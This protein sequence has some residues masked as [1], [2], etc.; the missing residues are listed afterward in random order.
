MK[1]FLILILLV[2]NSIIA[3][4]EAKELLLQS[5]LQKILTYHA[6]HVP[7]PDPK[8][9]WYG[10]SGFIHPVRTPS[11]RIVTDDFPRDHLHQHGIMMAWT[12]SIIDGKKVDFWNSHKKQGVI[13]H[14]ETIRADANKIIVKLQHFNTTIQPPQ[15]VLHET[16]E[17]T[18]VPH[19]TMHVFDLVSTQTNVMT[20]PLKLAKYKYGGLCV[21]GSEAWRKNGSFLTSN[22]KT[23]INGNHSRPK[24]VALYGKIDGATCGIA[25]LGH[26][27]NFRAPQP[28]RIHPEFPYF[29]YAPMVTGE[30]KIEPAKPFISRYRF[31]AFD[32]EPATQKLNALWNSYTGR[33]N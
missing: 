13:K 25:C 23:R 2:C 26:P 3:A 15:V 12:S 5:D 22:G 4:Q 24:W 17:L 9:P 30:F 19:P 1:T 8:Q 27:K 31:A 21:R 14:V 28:V 20:K 32:G 10:R 7:S 33:A 18:H 11:G 29:S 16:W 6:A